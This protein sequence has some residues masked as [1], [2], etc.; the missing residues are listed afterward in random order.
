MLINLAAAA[1]QSYPVT[2]AGFMVGVGFLGIFGEGNYQAF[3]SGSHTFTVP[4]GVSSIRVRVCGGGGGGGTSSTGGGGG[5]GYAHSTL[6]V[7]AG[8]TYVVSVAPSATYFS[9]GSA[10]SFGSLLSATGGIKGGIGGIGIGGDFI[11][12][13]GSGGSGY[14]SGG[15]AGSQL[16]N[17][18][19]GGSSSSGY[20][21]GG[22]GVGKGTPTAYHTG[23]SAFFGGK[24]IFGESAPSTGAS[25]LY[26]FPFDSFTGGGGQYTST[27]DLHHGGSGGGGSSG[28][29]TYMGNGGDGGGGGYCDNATG[30]NGGLGG[31]G[32][33]GGN[34]GNGGGGFVV[35]EW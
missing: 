32:G 1:T 13:G 33:N 30:G 7:S 8:S 4:E 23:G 29:S 35:V 3:A 22:G 5:G 10:S 24:N 11:A 9:S 12:R 14:G 16:G 26:R 2:N 19:D 31:G 20:V 6:T 21:S 18:G 34:G 15:G 25:F 28:S 27:A 17:G